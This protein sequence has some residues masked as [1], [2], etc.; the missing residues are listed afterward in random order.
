MSLTW[1]SPVPEDGG[2]LLASGRGLLDVLVREPHLQ[3]GGSLVVHMGKQAGGPHPSQLSV[4]MSEPFFSGSA[5]TSSVSGI[6]SMG[7]GLAP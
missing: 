5:M 1:R 2:V 7:N 3:L 4:G 6:T